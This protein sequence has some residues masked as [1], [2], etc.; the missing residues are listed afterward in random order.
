MALNRVREL[1]LGDAKLTELFAGDKNALWRQLATD[2]Y[3]FAAKPI[4]ESQHDVRQDDVIPALVIAL[5]ISEPLR[6][7]LAAKKLTQKYW[8]EWFAELIVDRLWDQLQAA[9]RKGAR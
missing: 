5:Q 9:H 7:Y 6:N 8:Y 3:D 2:A 4:L 1:A